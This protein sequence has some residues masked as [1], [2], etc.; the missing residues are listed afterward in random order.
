MCSPL[1]LTYAVAASSA[2]ALVAIAGW[3]CGILPLLCLMGLIILIPLLYGLQR[4]NGPSATGL[5]SVCLCIPFFVATYRPEQFHYPLIHHYSELDFDLFLNV[6]KM[7]TGYL[8][9][10]WLWQQERCQPWQ[11]S[12]IIGLAAGLSLV[13]V[14]HLLFGYEWLP[15]WPHGTLYFFAVNLGA[16][17]LAEEAF[18]RLAIQRPLQRITGS[19]TLAVAATTL[20]FVIAH[21]PANL[22]AASLIGVA[23]LIYALVYSYSKRFSAALTCHFAVNALHFTLLSYP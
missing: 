17:V 9:L 16:T 10:T 20:L 13:L 18:F 12:V 6:G 1:P 2:L 8:L 5:W 22:K 15:K 21:N 4:L 19:Q 14:A 7:L 3:A 23:G 11:R